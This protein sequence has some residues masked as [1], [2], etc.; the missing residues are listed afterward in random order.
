MISA[1]EVAILAKIICIL[2]LICS[3]FVFAGYDKEE[4]KRIWDHSQKADGLENWQK[5]LSVQEKNGEVNAP[6]DNPD[7]ELYRQEG[8]GKEAQKITKADAENFSPPEDESVMADQGRKIASGKSDAAQALRVMQDSTDENNPAVA[9]NL[10]E[11]DK[12]LEEATKIYQKGIM[13]EL[14]KLKNEGIDFDCV[15]FEG[16]SHLRDDPF[17]MG[18]EEKEVKEPIPETFF[19]EKLFN[20]YD[21]F[22]DL[23]IH[24]RRFSSTR[25]DV[26]LLSSNIPHKLNNGIFTF[27]IDDKSGNYNKRESTNRRGWFGNEFFRTHTKYTKDITLELDVKKDPRV[28]AEFSIYDLEYKQF[29]S[30]SVNGQNVFVGPYGGSSLTDL[31]SESEYKYFVKVSFGVIVRRREHEVLP[32]VSTGSRTYL[33]G[34]DTTYHGRDEGYRQPRSYNKIAKIDIRPYL[35]LGRNSIVIR[36]ISIDGAYLSAGIKSFERICLQW[37]DPVWN[38]RTTLKKTGDITERTSGGSQR[39]DEEIEWAKEGEHDW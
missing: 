22:E 39:P 24:C 15:T 33:V 1:R 4:F 17:V 18:W 32:R 29:V 26:R 34:E 37:S 30:V 20:T 28:F 25:E 13:A 31:N 3:S 6:V 10:R 27:T 16:K 19:C 11:V 2:G 12:A 14:D 5:P 8:E 23:E 9:N 36:S 7:I 38:E 35:K 21:A